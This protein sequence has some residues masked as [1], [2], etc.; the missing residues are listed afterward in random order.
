MLSDVEEGDNLMLMRLTP[1]ATL[2][3]TAAPESVHIGV[4]KWKS[5]SPLPPL[6]SKTLHQTFSS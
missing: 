6:N 3:K 5:I 2:V 1:V 4:S